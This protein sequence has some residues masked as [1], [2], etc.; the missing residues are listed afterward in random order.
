MVFVNR[1]L[2]LDRI[3]QI[4]RAAVTGRVER[5]LAMVGVRR[6]GKSRLIEHYVESAPPLPV[7]VVQVDAASTTIQAFLLAMVRETIN[8]IARYRGQASLPRGGPVEMASLAAALDPRLAPE[9]S[10]ALALTQARRIDGQEVL[11]AALAFPENISQVVD[12][13]L[14]VIADEFQHLTDLAVYPP[15]DGGRRRSVEA[16]RLSLLAV[17]RA[18]IERRPRVGWVVTGSGVRLLRSILGKGPLMGRF[19]EI[20]VGP[21]DADDTERLADAVWA[22]L[23]V[24]ATDSA[25]MR[26]YRLTQGHPFYA[27][28]TC[29][30]AAVAA[31][32]QDQAVS[33][34]MVDGAFIDA[35]R[36]PQGQIAIAC[37]EMFDSLGDRAPALRGLLQ[38]L[39]QGEPLGAVELAEHM[40]LT[41][42][43]AVY[44][45]AEEL[46]R[47]G[48]IE[49]VT[50]GVTVTPETA[51]EAGQASLPDQTREPEFTSRFV[52]TD[53][54]FRYW[55]ARAS[56]PLSPK[57]VLLNPGAARRAANQYEEAFLRQREEQGPLRE[58]YL[59]DLCRSFAGQMIEGRRLGVPGRHVT[60]PHVSSVERIVAFDQRGEVF[61]QASEVEL[62]LCFGDDQ[63]WLGEVRDRRRR[64]SAEDIRLAARKAA[65][66]RLAHGLS[67]GP[68]WFV[69]ISGFEER[70]RE[71]AQRLGVYISTLRDVE[72]IRNVTATARKG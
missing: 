43:P 2:E 39:A 22:E 47:L 62:D 53:P 17:V 1:R 9:V 3:A 59:R 54:A 4:A 34:S 15:F 41:S 8:A 32:R 30:E 36:Q 46:Q 68:L 60:L 70:A 13:P 25:R 65:F 6:I 44:R 61:G 27:D 45:Y 28:V 51:P 35:V 57:P 52:F 56:D 5:H 29:R 48:M 23:G 69:S 21:F 50:N 12:T 71:E 58:G 38:A 40:H 24:E 26:A 19:D 20:Q 11:A 66:L 49:E 63:V 37:K 16:A 55:V 72:A 18:H 67:A 33:A 7:V 31:L 42:V 64:T 14:L 10:R